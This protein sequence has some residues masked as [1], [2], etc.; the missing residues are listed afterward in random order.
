MSYDIT[1][2]THF[3]HYAIVDKWGDRKEGFEEKI[4]TSIQ[5]TVAKGDVVIHLGDFA[6]YKH[7]MWAE[8]F[9]EACNGA[10]V[11]LIKGNHD[12]HSNSWWLDRG[13]DFVAESFMMERHG[14]R[15][16]FTHKP[17]P[18]A[19][20]YDI[21]VHGHLHNTGHRDMEYQAIKHDG[22]LLIEIES[23]FDIR[24]LDKLIQKKIQEMG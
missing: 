23:S 21:G 4:L 19:D 8:R 11:W 15:V 12:K 22:Q 16:L 13:F 18:K 24:N 10:K 20:S 5:K 14:K 9:I 6:W 7:K 2:D 17:Q 3:N 1:S